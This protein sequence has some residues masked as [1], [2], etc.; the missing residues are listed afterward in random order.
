MACFVSL[1][2]VNV[3]CKIQILQVPYK[4]VAYFSCTKPF[5]MLAKF[6]KRNA[7]AVDDLTFSILSSSSVSKNFSFSY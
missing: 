2:A 6:L 5:V 4:S 1:K 3:K 7:E